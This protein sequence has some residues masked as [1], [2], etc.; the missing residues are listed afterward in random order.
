MGK[1]FPFPF[2]VS[3]V[4]ISQKIK[5]L[6]HQ[7]SNENYK[8]HIENQ[9]QNRLPNFVCNNHFCEIVHTLWAF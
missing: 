1:T 7:I 6:T 2:I 9:N 8:N 3:I 5:F 4:Q